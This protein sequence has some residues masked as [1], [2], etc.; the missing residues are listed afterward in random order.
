MLTI[1]IALTTAGAAPH[2]ICSLVPVA[3]FR[4]TAVTYLVGAAVPDTAPAGLGAT[5]PSEAGGHW[6]AGRARA[7]FGQ[8]IRVDRLAG[9]DSAVLERAFMR[10]DAREVVVVPWDYGPDCR[11]VVWGRSFRWVETAAPGFYRL[12][13]RPESEWTT[14]RPVLDAFRADLEPYPHGIFFQ[15]G[16]RGTHAVRTG[17]ALTPAEYFSLYSALPPSS[18]ASERPQAARAILDA[19]E[20]THPDLAA[21]YPA[22]AALQFAR[23]ILD[24]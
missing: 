8:V 6:G 18:V 16:Y 20:R 14:G 17:P 13:P 3:V 2:P 24:R 12:R 21:K 15:R 9:A 5:R 11:A 19:W 22:T 4:D 7:V 23:A 10:L 1:L